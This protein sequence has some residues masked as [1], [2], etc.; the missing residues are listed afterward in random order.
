MCLFNPV[1]PTCP[2]SPNE[3]PKSISWTAFAQVVIEFAFE[4]TGTAWL[5]MCCFVLK[6]EKHYVLP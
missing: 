3:T 1:R 4:N 2:D 5:H 6:D